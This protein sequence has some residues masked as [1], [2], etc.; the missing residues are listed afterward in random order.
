AIMLDNLSPSWTNPA[1]ITGPSSLCAGQTGDYFAPNN[2][3]TYQWIV[4]AGWTVVSGQGTRQARIRAGSNTGTIRA[5]P[6]CGNPVLSFG[7]DVFTNAV[8]IDGPSSICP[9]STNQYSVTQYPG[10]SYTW[11]ASGDVSIVMGQG[12]N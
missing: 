1:A 7:V 10:A 2:G 5:N 11:S 3:A 9:Y 6:S 4:P 8:S 12:T